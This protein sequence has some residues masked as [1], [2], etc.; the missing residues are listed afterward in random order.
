M[1]LDGRQH[2]PLTPHMPTSP[3]SQGAM[4]LQ[5]LQPLLLRITVGEGS[6]SEKMQSLSL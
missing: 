2:A 5:F 4:S 3:H 1:S 6:H